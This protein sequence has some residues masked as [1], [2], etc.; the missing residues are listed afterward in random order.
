MSNAI[1]AHNLDIGYVNGTVATTVLSDVNLDI[2]KG[3]FLTI[4]G[5]SGCGKSTLL[6]VLADLLDPISGDATILGTSPSIVRQQRKTGFVFQESTLLPWRNVWDN[7]RLPSMV[8][9][10]NALPT[11]SERIQE[12]LD[13]MGISDFGKRYPH[14]LSG[15]QRQ[16]VAIARALLHEPDILFMDEPFGALDEITRDRLNDELLDIWRRANMTILFVTHSIQEAI[17][18]G[19]RCMVMK[20]N[21]G[22]IVALKDLRKYKQADNSCNRDDANLLM[23]MAELRNELVY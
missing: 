22:R 8:G 19:Q 1:E 18:L 23:A 3:E 4:L 16:R 13:M 10:K 5:T 2:P 17:Y 7:I 6:R 14:Q 9:G 21:P 11:T 15:G 20:S 12:L